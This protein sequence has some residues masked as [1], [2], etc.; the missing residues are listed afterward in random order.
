[1][2]KIMTDYAKRIAEAVREAAKAGFIA[3]A[4]HPQHL[5]TT[6]DIAESAD[7]YA[8]LYVSRDRDA[9][10]AS[11]PKSQYSAGAQ[12]SQ[13]VLTDAEIEAA[14]VN[15]N[16]GHTQYRDLLAASV[17]KKLVGYHCGHTITVIMQELHLIGK[18][19]IVTKRGKRFVSLAY[20]HSMICS[21]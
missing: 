3:A 12:D 14:F 10:I 15:T 18:T 7:R 21:G 8:D 11:V 17:F 2:D 20:N 9:I 5:K 13:E 6:K 16:F 19:G 4:K 1:M